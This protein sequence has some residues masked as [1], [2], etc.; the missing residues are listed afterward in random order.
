MADD[1]PRDGAPPEPAA[2]RA[3]SEARA[4]YPKS[5]K[6]VAH[7]LA[8][9]SRVLAREGYARTSLLDIARE[10]GM[11]KG[12]V[13]YHFPTKEALVGK[14]LERAL[15]NIAMS[16]LAA[17]ADATD[18]PLQGLRSAMR[19]L[20]RLRRARTDEVAVVADL[21][22]QALHD[23]SLRPPLAAYY[24][25]AAQQLSAHL[26]PTLASVGLRLR[27]PAP[28]VPRLVV[29]LLDGLVMQHFVDGDALDDDHVLFAV[30][31]MVLS[32][33]EPTESWI[34]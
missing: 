13:H 26:E 10:A 6:S 19:E 3:G 32:L 20:W 30:E 28:L 24:G 27:V 25:F 29:G 1:S 9:A 12:A 11:S 15:E 33:F 16:T 14:V 31:T 18:D 7:I 22:A 4:R 2:P 23:P 5:E 8:A 21:L 34:G 17:V